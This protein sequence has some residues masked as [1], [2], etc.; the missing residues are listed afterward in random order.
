MDPPLSQSLNPGLKSKACTSRFHIQSGCTDVLQQQIHESIVAE[1]SLSHADKS[2][3]ILY[4][5][6]I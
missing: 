2:E 1:L 5:T 6:P 4:K 3:P